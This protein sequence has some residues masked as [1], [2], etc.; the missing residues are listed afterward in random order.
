MPP[1]PAE[2]FSDKAFFRRAIM[3]KNNIRIAT[4][5]DI[6]GLPGAECNHTHGNAGLAREDRQD[7][8][9]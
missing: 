8:A 6:Q 7:M 4:P 3:H 1:R 9:K 5:P 2:T